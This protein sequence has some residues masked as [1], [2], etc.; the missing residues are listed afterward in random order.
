[1]SQA[2]HLS[3]GREVLRDELRKLEKAAQAALQEPRSRTEAIEE[4]NRRLPDGLPNLSPTTVGGWFEK[5]TP[6]KDFSSLWALLRVLLEWSGRRPAEALTGPERGRVN[7]QWIS[8]EELWRRRHAQAQGQRTPSAPTTPPLVTAYLTAARDAA[9][10]H[11]YPAALSAPGMPALAD[12]YVRQQVRSPAAASQDG[13]NPEDTTAAGIRAGSAVPATEVFGADHDM[14]VLLGGPGGGKSTLFRTYLADSAGRWLAGQ[15]GKTIPVLVNAGALNGM[16]P[17]PT[18]LAKAVTGDLR[19][20]G[21]LD[22]LTAGFFRHPPRA[23]VAWLL[24]VDGLDEISDAETRSAILGTLAGATAVAPGLYRFVVATRPLP[25]SELSALGANVPRYEL[26]PF[27]HDD[28]LTFATGWFGDLGDPSR[29]A[30]AFVAGLYRSSLDVMARTPLIASMLCQLYAA[31]P[32][33]PLPDGRTAAYDSFVE[34]IYG[35]NAHKNIRNTHKDAIRRLKDRHQ[36]PVDNQAAGQAAEQVRQHLPGLIDHLAH[37]RINGNTARAVQVLTSHPHAKRPHKVRQDLWDSFL[38]DLVRSTGILIQRAN[39]LDFLHQTLLEYH[40]A[41]HA[42]RNDQA[43]A[44]LLHDLKALSNAPAGDPWQP[45][46]LDPSY[47]GFLLDGLLIPEDRIAAETIQYVE[48]L[49]AHGGEA[50]CPF[51]LN[52]VALRTRLPTKLT[53]RRLT[54]FASDIT[55]DDFNRFASAEA[56]A[57]IEGYRDAGAKLLAQL[58][59]DT[60][61]IGIYRVFAALCLARVEGYRDAGAELLAQLAIDPTLESFNRARAADAVAKF[62]RHAEASWTDNR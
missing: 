40:A 46:D 57:G 26:Q 10:R 41:R 37:E 6:A 36:I 54:Q 50:V 23:K 55:P 13:M 62:D 32:A 15:A 4:A 11:P 39:D 17:L 34:L 7:A 38:S 25:L 30:A 52:Q 48:E 53:A 28:L 61:C 47:L 14:C 33:Q 1:M 2:A 27:S 43:R 22:E 60:F 51:L 19:R 45:P 3:A 20:A 12:V 8:T 35:Q 59:N 29:H 58:A 56:L 16:D 31:D 42:T 49:T 24:L 21:L 18:A 44:Q 9:A 5:G